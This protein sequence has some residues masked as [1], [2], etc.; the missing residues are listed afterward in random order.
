MKTVV[1]AGEMPVDDGD[2]DQCRPV[3][4]KS[5]RSLSSG[6]S[7]RF[8]AGRLSRNTGDRQAA[9]LPRSSIEGHVVRSIIRCPICSK[10]FNN[11]SA[12]AKHKLTHSDERK[13]TC[14]KCSKAFKRQDHL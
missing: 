8:N 12:L 10:L 9:R 1:L 14:T 11:S 7:S 2:L 4:F 5:R 3:S 6:R 13:Y